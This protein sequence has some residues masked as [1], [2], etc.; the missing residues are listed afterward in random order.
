MRGRAGD[1]QI[2]FIRGFSCWKGASAQR[3]RLT[4]TLVD[5]FAF[6]QRTRHPPVHTLYSEGKR[7]DHDQAAD[8]RRD[9]RRLAEKQPAQVVAALA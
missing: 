6:H 4:P 7:R 2:R 3:R 8:D 5:P 9:G 1:S